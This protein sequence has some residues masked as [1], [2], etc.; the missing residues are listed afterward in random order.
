MVE[1]WLLAVEFPGRTSKDEAEASKL[2]TFTYKF[3]WDLLYTVRTLTLKWKFGYIYYFPSTG[4][5]VRPYPVGPRHWQNMGLPH[6]A[7]LV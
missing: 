4:Y 1:P 2:Q 6:I 5:P 7:T 3:R